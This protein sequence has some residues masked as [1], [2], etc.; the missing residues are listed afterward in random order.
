MTRD[1]GQKILA[2]TH[3]KQQQLYTLDYMNMPGIP[4]PA[5]AKE[6]AK[7]HESNPNAIVSWYANPHTGPENPDYMRRAHGYTAYKFNYDAS[8]NYVWYRYNWNDWACPHESNLR[9]LMMV[10]ATRNNVLDTLAWEGIR[11]GMDDIRYATKLKEV[12][13][14]ALE[15]ESGKI[16][17]AGREAVSFLAYADEQRQDIN[18]F[19]IECINYILELTELMKGEN[20]K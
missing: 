8:A 14:K 16:H 10:Y 13:N 9:G 4:E 6:V 20:V 12:A 18:A 11:E 5:R 17:F 7:F 3:P 15:S 19:R 2:T 1:A